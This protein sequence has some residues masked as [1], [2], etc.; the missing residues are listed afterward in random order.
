MKN[1][2]HHQCAKNQIER[3]LVAHIHD[4]D[5]GYW[6]RCGSNSRYQ[7]NSCHY[8]SL[9]G[10]LKVITL[11]EHMYSCYK[12]FDMKGSANKYFLLYSYPKVNRQIFI[13][14]SFDV[15]KHNRSNNVYVI[16]IQQ[17][18]MRHEHIYKETFFE[19]FSSIENTCYAI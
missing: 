3:K 1:P 17:L 9:M 12:W 15:I 2:L 10:V 7:R 19:S 16:S 14:N 6:S 4:N 5:I 18:F 11:P 8:I 13:R